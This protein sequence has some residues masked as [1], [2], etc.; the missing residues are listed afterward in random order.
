MAKWLSTELLLLTT[1]PKTVDPERFVQLLRV[2][3]A[4]TGRKQAELARASSVTA[5]MVSKVLKGKAQPNLANFCKFQAAFL[6]AHGG[7]TQA[8]QV[9]QMAA[10]LGGDLDEADLLAIAKAVERYQ[11]PGGGHHH[12]P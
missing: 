8:R 10:L 2:Y 12:F 11:R 9:T 5:S 7:I 1:M 4:K 6:V 3:L